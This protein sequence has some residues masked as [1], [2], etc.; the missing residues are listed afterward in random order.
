MILIEKIKR[1]IERPERLL[2]GIQ[3]RWAHYFNNQKLLVEALYYLQIGH[4]LD[5]VNPK[6]FT[7]KTQWLKVYDHNPLYHKMVD[8]H[9]V[10]DYV[11]SIVGEEYVIPTLGIW[12]AFDDIDFDKL[13]SRFVLKTT[14]GGG[15][16]GVVICKDKTQFNFFE[17][18]VKLEASMKNDIYKSLGEWVYKGITPRIIAEQYMEDIDTRTNSV[19][20]LVDYKFWCFNGVPTYLFYASNRQNC[21]HKPPYF[22]YFDMN[23]N[24][25]PIKS[26]GH[27]NSAVKTLNIACFE[28][29][30]RIAARLS[31]NIPFVRVDL[32][33]IC[34]KVYF[35]ELTFYHDSGLVPFEPQDW[36]EKIGRLLQLPNMGG[37]KSLNLIRSQYAM[38][39]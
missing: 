37:V 23:L 12:D 34:G 2:L 25:L 17:A 3:L 38:A 4:K 22:D 39:A 20:D 30:K 16:T 24:K 9:L 31:Q 36:D 5:L 19:K 29:M 14:N 15:N 8:K 10:K 28:E 32:Y 35:G 27:E 1:V 26:K 21:E 11:S 6:T 33:Q 13:P 18:K 7:A